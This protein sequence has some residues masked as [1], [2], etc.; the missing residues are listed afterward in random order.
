LCPQAS[1]TIIKD[2]FDWIPPSPGLLKLNI[3][4]VVHQNSRSIG[5]GV[6][7]RDEKGKVL[8]A[9]SSQLCGSFST[10]VSQFLTLQEG[11]MLAKF[12]NFLVGIIE[13]VSS[14]VSTFLNSPDSNLGD[15][16]FIVNDIRATLSDIGRRKCQAVPISGIALAQNLAAIAFSSVRERLWLG[17]SPYCFSLQ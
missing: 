14:S 10:E 13:V 1:A 9:R 6:A 5:I 15:I 11:L 2:P 3:G 7:I 4:A 17:P 8:V 16:R 12:Y